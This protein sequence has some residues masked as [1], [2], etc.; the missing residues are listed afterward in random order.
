MT[1][2]V[3]RCLKRKTMLVWVKEYISK[4][5]TTCKSLWNLQE[6]Y[7]AFKEKHPNLYIGFSRFSALRP[8]WYVLAGWK[9]TYS[10]C[11]CSTHQ[12]VMLLINAM[13]WDLTYKNL[14]KNIICNHES[15]KCIMHRCEYYPGTA[16][17]DLLNNFLIRNSTNMKMI[18][19]L[20]TVSETLRI[21]Q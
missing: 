17:L 11:V 13:D 3:D 9:M 20:I 2:S 16:T 19:N 10:V 15:N 8:K 21:E 4:S 14:I 12:N 6:L 7:I 18:R 5:L 1:I